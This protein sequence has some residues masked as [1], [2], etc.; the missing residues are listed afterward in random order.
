M[1]ELKEWNT[2]SI[3][4]RAVEFGASHACAPSTSIAGSICGFRQCYCGSSWYLCYCILNAQKSSFFVIVIDVLIVAEL[5]VL[6]FWKLMEVRK[7][8][9]TK[10]KYQ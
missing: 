10:L 2:G 8:K 6:L 4:V 3:P 7:A 5:L 9:P 1:N